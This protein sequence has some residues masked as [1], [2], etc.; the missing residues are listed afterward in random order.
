[1]IEEDR[2]PSRFSRAFAAALRGYIKQ[3]DISQ[4]AVAKASNYSTGYV[5]GRLNGHHAVDTDMVD[6]VAELT[7]VS[8]F[9]LHQILIRRMSE[10]DDAVDRMVSE[11]VK[12][13]D[14]AAASAAKAA[15][16]I[17]PRRRRGRRA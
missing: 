11:A 16:D 9:D 14:A 3:N 7:G 4:R 17:P 1:M 2:T 10:V 8:P 13:D 6:A 5:S 12:R 15:A